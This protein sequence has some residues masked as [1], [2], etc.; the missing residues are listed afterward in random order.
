MKNFILFLAIFQSISVLAQEFNYSIKTTKLIE[1]QYSNATLIIKG[2]HESS[3]T[4]RRLDKQIVID[5]RAE[6]LELVTAHPDNT[7][8]GFYIGESNDQLQ[9]LRQDIGK[10]SFEIL[11]PD[12]SEIRI[13]EKGWFGG[14]VTLENVRSVDIE[15]TNSDIDLRNIRGGSYARSTS[16]DISSE[17]IQLPIDFKSISGVVSIKLDDGIRADLQ[18]KTISGII[19]TD[20]DIQNTKEHK[21][22]VMTQVGNIRKLNYKLNGGG[23]LVKAQSISGRVKIIT[24]N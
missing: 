13:K 7:G 15:C 18:V 3:I 16:G 22:T 12:N 6:G 9:I 19:Q 17:S 1:I 14:S 21:G 2:H 5:E 20:L 24:K 23:S 11:V 4:I 10:G 8:I